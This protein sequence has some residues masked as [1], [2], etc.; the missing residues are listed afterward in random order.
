MFIILK[1]KNIT[2]DDKKFILF[3]IDMYLSYGEEL[4]IFPSEKEKSIIISKI[5]KIKN[6][7]KIEICDD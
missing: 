5:E 4:N 2:Y 3:V 1:R 6:K 7:L